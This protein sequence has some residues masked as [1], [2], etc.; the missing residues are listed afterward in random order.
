MRK[1]IAIILFIAA[2]DI[3]LSSVSAQS[4][5]EYLNFVRE[6][7]MGAGISESIINREFHDLKPDPRVLAL[8]RKQPEF[9]QTTEDYLK[10]RLS[11]NRISDGRKLRK[12]YNEDL[13]AVERSYQVDANYIIAFWGLETNYGRYQG[14]YSVIRSLATLG[15]DPRRHS[16]FTRELLSALKILE[17]GHV[18]SRF[19]VGAWAGA[20][21]QSQFMPSS[22]FD[23]A[24]DFDGDGKKDIWNSELDVFASIANYLHKNG[25]VYSELWGKRIKVE[26]EIYDLFPPKSGESGCRALNHHSAKLPLENWKN[27][28]IDSGK[29]AMG[30]T[31]ALLRLSDAPDQTYLVGSNFETI[32]QYNCAN[33][34]AVSVGLLADHLA[35]I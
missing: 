19:F 12:L 35:E 11:D 4:F 25:W 27:L 32:L 16:F 21:G 13:L 34:Y 33:K 10:A 30:K 29:L 7:A 17:Q 8:D 15:H 22:F 24:Q 23:Y 31:Y 28:G 3:S 6:K 20:M 26:K 14:N 1:H 5:Q 9:V 2:V 18:K